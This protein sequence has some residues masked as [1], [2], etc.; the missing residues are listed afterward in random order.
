MNDEVI[1]EDIDLS[2]LS[3]QMLILI[4]QFV[5]SLNAQTLSLGW[6]THN[7]N[8]GSKRMI[9]LTFLPTRVVG[10]VSMVWEAKT[11]PLLFGFLFFFNENLCW[12][13]VTL[14]KL[15]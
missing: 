2:Y 10:R 13:F 7:C 4:V 12:K 3:L 1:R 15:F 9:C 14:N 8:F 6:K 5:I 11:T